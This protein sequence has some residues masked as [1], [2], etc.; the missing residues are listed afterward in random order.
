MFKKILLLAV[1]CF[2]GSAYAQ[3]DDII[4]SKDWVRA[5]AGNKR[6]TAAYMDIQNKSNEADVLFKVTSPI[7]DKIELHKVVPDDKNILQM[8]Q[9]DRIVV[10]AGQVIH[11]APKALHIMIFDLKKLLKAGNEIE[12]TLHFEKAGKIKLNLPVKSIA[13]ENGK[14]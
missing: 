10:P 4:I 2:T 9:I 7:S 8:V 5:T 13:A 3:T 1:L 12:L 11:L 14:H 6:I